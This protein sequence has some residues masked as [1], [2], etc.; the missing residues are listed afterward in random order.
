[1]RM[2]IVPLVLVALAGFF[3]AGPPPPRTAAPRLIRM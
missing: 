1:M 3:D 2:R